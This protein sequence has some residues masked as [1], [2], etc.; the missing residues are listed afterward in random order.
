MLFQRTRVQFNGSSQLSV[1][2]AQG[3]QATYRH[4]NKTPM[5]IY[6]KNKTK[7]SVALPLGSGFEV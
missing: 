2:M 5:S 7:L 4:V 3:D 1:T 6:N